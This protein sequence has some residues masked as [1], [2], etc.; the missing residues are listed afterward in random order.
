MPTVARSDRA[1]ARDGP[2]RRDPLGRLRRLRR[3]RA[4]AIAS[5]ASGSRLVFTAD[6][7]YR[8]GKDV[9]LKPIVDEALELVGGTSSSTSSCWQRGTPRSAALNAPRDMTWDDFLERGDGQSSDV[10]ADGGERAGV[11]PRDLGHDRASR[12]WRST[13]TAAIRSTSSAW[14]AGASA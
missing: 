10:R 1:D 11:H 2:H 4:R 3:A 13:R 14:G 5:Q 9:A 7:T 8:K 6:V 12:S